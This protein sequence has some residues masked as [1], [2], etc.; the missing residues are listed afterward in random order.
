MLA[1]NSP[2]RILASIIRHICI[3]KGTQIDSSE[4]ARARTSP[5]YYHIL[6]TNHHLRWIR[7]PRSSST[8]SSTTSHIPACIPL[9]SLRGV[10]EGGAKNARLPPLLSRPKTTW[11]FG[12]G[13]SHRT[14]MASLPTFAPLSYPISTLGANLRCSVAYSRNSPLSRVSGSQPPISRDLMSF[15]AL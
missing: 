1:I 9:H 8:K 13:T 10:G 12:V 7:S 6:A 3:R 5:P 14:H 2:R 15:R 11:S 4:S